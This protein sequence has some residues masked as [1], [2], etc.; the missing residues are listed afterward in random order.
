VELIFYNTYGAV[1]AALAS[2]FYR[3][4]RMVADVKA[5]VTEAKLA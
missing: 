2:S 5:M 4:S 3:M 1:V